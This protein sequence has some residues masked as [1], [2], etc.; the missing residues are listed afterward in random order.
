[1]GYAAR[2]DAID[3]SPVPALS[4]TPAPS[5]GRGSLVR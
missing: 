2:M 4:P 1:M 3:V 5:R